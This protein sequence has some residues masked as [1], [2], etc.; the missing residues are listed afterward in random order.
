[1]PLPRTLN[2]P[3]IEFMNPIPLFPFAWCCFMAADFGSN[4][5]SFVGKISK[6]VK[7]ISEC[8]TVGDCSAS[9]GIN[10]QDRRKPVDLPAVL[11]DSRWETHTQEK[12]RRG[13]KQEPLVILPLVVQPAANARSRLSRCCRLLELKERNKIGDKLRKVETPLTR[14][15]GKRCERE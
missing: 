8:G 1:M 5:F 6:G 14:T 12:G 11:C 9:R 10:T 4:F 15:S 13:G 7:T 3:S 2:S